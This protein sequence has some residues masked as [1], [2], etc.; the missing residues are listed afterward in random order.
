MI[1]IG[2]ILTGISTTI[3]TAQKA[4]DLSKQMNNLEL[5]EVIMELKEEL[6][7]IRSKVMQLK[8]ESDALKEQ[9]KIKED[10]SRLKL[11]DEVLVDPENAGIVYCVKCR[12]DNGK[13]SVMTE[14]SAD[15]KYSKAKQYECKT[16]G[17]AAKPYHLNFTGY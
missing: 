14:S 4:Y 13:K 8:E 1:G 17:H 12:E 5:K 16:C 11:V 6:L 7:E 10:L 9:A 2:T 15:I 3:S